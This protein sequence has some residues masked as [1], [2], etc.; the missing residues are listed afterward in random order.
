MFCAVVGQV[1]LS[2]AGGYIKHRVQTNNKNSEDVE[3]RINGGVTP[4]DSIVQLQ[5]LSI[6]R[7]GWT[8]YAFFCIPCAQL[9]VN[10]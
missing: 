8:H 10:G 7:K 2:R 1:A 9:T 6:L 5:P 4:I 3:T